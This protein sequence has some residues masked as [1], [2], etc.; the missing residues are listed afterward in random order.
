MTAKTRLHIRLLFRV[1]TI[2]V[3]GLIFIHDTKVQVPEKLPSKGKVA[4][5][6]LVLLLSIQVDVRREHRER[7]P[8]RQEARSRHHG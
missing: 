6:Q 8:P 1:G 2:I 7:S 5:S 3:W 4:R